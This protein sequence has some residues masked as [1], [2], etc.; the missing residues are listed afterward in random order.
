MNKIEKYKNI[1][2]LGIGGIGMSALARFFNS[3]NKNVFGYDQHQTEITDELLSEGVDVFFDDDVSCIPHIF[4]KNNSENLIIYTSAIS[5]NNSLFSFFNAKDFVFKKRSVVL[6]LISEK[7]FTIA[8]AGTHG[9]TTTSAL[10]TCLLKESNI[11]LTSFVGGVSRNYKSNFICSNKSNDSNIL[12]VEADEFDKSFLELYPDIAVITSIDNDHLDTYE[13]FEDIKSAFHQFSKQIKNGG[14]LILEENISDNFE[15]ITHV[16]KYTY[17]SVA[18][19]DIYSKKIKRN[20][21]F[22]NF[23]IELS[24]KAKK[25]LFEDKPL[26]NEFILPMPGL[27][28]LSNTLAAITVCMILKIDITEIVK[29]LKY[30]KGINRRF[31]VHIDSIK[32]VYIDDYAHHPKEIMMTLLATKELFPKRKLTVVFQPHLYSR[33]KDFAQEFA[34]SLKIAEELIITNIFPAREQP[35]VGVDSNLILDFCSNEK[36][37]ICNKSEVLDVLSENEI[38]VLVTLGAGDISTLVEPIKHMLN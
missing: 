36:K 14:S 16:N 20:G 30:F 37:Q 8:I 7:F 31:D 38:D 25:L 4:Q 35:I 27:H 23:N 10:L 9:K 24:S 19:S 13:N 21:T 32:N 26:V 6:G 5:E 2:L 34:S 22:V 33:T 15:D 3:Q 29:S 11:N 28:N 1:L 12:V 17:S 18:I